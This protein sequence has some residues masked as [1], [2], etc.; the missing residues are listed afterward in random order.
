MSSHR[1]LNRGAVCAVVLFGFVS[2]PACGSD[3]ANDG[4]RE[5]FETRSAITIGAVTD[6][7]D[8][9]TLGYAP[10]DSPLLAVEFEDGTEATATASAV[11]LEDLGLGTDVLNGSDVRMTWGDLYLIFEDGRTRHPGARGDGS[12]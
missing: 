12:R 3:D 10:L 8:P 11:L 4:G 5:N 1:R 2:V 7:L 9:S 6:E